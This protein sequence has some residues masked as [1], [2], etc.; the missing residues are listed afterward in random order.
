MRQNEKGAH[1][2]RC[3]PAWA[4]PT[5]KRMFQSDPRNRYE[6]PGRGFDNG[7]LTYNNLPSYWEWIQGEGFVPCL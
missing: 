2:K 1:R 6:V 4:I 7:R 3:A 5:P